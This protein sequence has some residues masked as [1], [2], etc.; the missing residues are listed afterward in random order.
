MLSSKSINTLMI[1]L[2]DYFKSSV[3]MSGRV[4]A[5]DEVCSST[6][7]KEL[8]YTCKTIAAVFK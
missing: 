8:L 2:N 6:C 5:R 4:N 1:V 7:M 3:V